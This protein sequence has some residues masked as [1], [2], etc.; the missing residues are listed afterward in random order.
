MPQLREENKISSDD[1]I[2][3]GFSPPPLSF[4]SCGN[5]HNALFA[6]SLEATISGKQFPR[7]KREKK[8]TAKQIFSPMIGNVISCLN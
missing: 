5:D 4:S 1:W 2:M 6:S 7:L 3:F 8:A